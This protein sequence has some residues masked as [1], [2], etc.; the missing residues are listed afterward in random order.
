VLDP[1]ARE[2]V[3]RRLHAVE[4]RISEACRRAGRH[5]EDVTLVAVTKSAS[6]ELARLLVELGVR[7]LGES[8]PQE[9]WR[10]RA[11][12]PVP[13]HW[14]L[15]GHLQRNKIERTLPV[16]LIHSVDRIPLLT[17][18][19]QEGGRR[20]MVVDVLLEV[21]ASREPTKIG[22]AP[23][24]LP[25][26]ISEIANLHSVSVRGL[27]TMAAPSD[28]PQ[29]ARPT[30]ALLRE[31]QDELRGNLPSV[32]PLDQLS[33]GMSEDFEVAIEE[34]ATLVRLG[35]ILVEGLGKAS[36]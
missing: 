3:E 24:E 36:P 18:L 20:G 19:D 35:T 2:I 22:F 30:F 1:S 32:H 26:V 34:G 8:R 13:V 12:L 29:S 27:M 7:D 16:R 17:A 28:E 10:K 25:G 6:A 21:N 14:H 5:R 4:E 15:V 33:M 23:E 31:L 11:A 9:L